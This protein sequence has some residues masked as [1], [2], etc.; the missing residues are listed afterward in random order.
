MIKYIFKWNSKNNIFK[1]N[2]FNDCIY[3]SQYSYKNKRSNSSN[4]KNCSKTDI[5]SSKNNK[6]RLKA[7]EIVFLIK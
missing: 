5:N 3:K 1:Y 2:T 7:I 6:E 4:F